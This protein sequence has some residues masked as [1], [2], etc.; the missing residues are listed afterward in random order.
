MSIRN[1]QQI[2]EMDAAT[3]RAIDPA[4]PRSF[5]VAPRCGQAVSEPR[6]GFGRG[7][8]ADLSFQR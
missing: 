3:A 2:R 7:P 1:A 5:V 4:Y 6:T 8:G